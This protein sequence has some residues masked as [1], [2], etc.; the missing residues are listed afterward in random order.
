MSLYKQMVLEMN[1][2]AGK[3]MPEFRRTYLGSMPTKEEHER[4]KQKLSQPVHLVQKETE[5]GSSSTTLSSDKK[6]P[7]ASSRL[8]GS[9]VVG[10]SVSGWNFITFGGARPVYYGVKKESFRSNRKVVKDDVVVR[11]QFNRS[12]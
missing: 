3:A 9:Y 5:G 8:E 1:K 11:R 7:T 10:G 12:S 2:P 6:K 4:K